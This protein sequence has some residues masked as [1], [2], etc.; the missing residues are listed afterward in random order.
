M[1]DH[2]A[3]DLGATSDGGWQ[4]SGLTPAQLAWGVPSPPRSLWPARLA[5]AV[6][7]LLYLFLP[8]RLIPGP[9]YIVPALEGGMLLV[10]STVLP[11]SS[12]E[13][14]PKR[15]ILAIIAVA[16]VTVANLIN[17]GLLVHVMVSGH[18]SNGRE[19][20]FAAVAI[21]LT[22]VIVFSLWYWQLDRGGPQA[23]HN[24]NHREPDF[25]FPQMTTPGS[26]RPGWAPSFVDYF[27][28]SFTNA[29]AF[30]PTDTM[31]LTVIAK[32]LMTAQ[33]G[34]S[35]LTIALVA[36]RAVNILN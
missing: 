1:A 27:Y 11:H 26:A 3:P 13:E 32:A 17:L 23:R 31:P 28:V 16:I 18:V 30:S 14:S 7:I 35:L 4:S 21:W 5:V 34:A 8:E 36:A 22:N 15:R 10:L 2:A 12:V 9:R 20:V 24:P 33:S 29:T 19:L 25:L 6:A